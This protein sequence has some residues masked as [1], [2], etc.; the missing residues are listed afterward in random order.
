MKAAQPEDL[1]VA[2]AAVKVAGTEVMILVAQVARV[3]R[4]VRV[5]RA[6]KRII[7]L[8]RKRR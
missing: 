4:A 1:V 8:K 7:F 5:A 2:Q 6:A 3:A